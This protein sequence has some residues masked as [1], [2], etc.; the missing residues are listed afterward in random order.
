MNQL[1]AGRFGLTDHLCHFGIVVVEDFPEQEHG[2]L[3]GAKT[4]EDGKERWCCRDLG[5][6]PH[7]SR[8]METNAPI[9]EHRKK[10][11]EDTANGV[12]SKFCHV[13]NPS[14]I[15]SNEEHPTFQYAPSGTVACK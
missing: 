2:P 12:A 9:P 7:D 14:R 10:M 15:R 4:L 6:L 13:A 3:I 8:D 1:A 11:Q 5:N